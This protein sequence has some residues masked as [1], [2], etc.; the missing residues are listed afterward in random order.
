[1]GRPRKRK[2][3]HVVFDTN[4]IFTKTPEELVSADAA[5]AIREHSR[6]GDLDVKWIIPAIVRKE[7]EYQMHREFRTVLGSARR[8]AVLF[9]EPWDL[10]DDKVR[11]AI[12]AAIEKQAAQLNVVFRDCDAGRVDWVSMMHASAFRLPPFEAGQ[13]EKGFRDAIVCET[14]CQVVGDLVGGDTAVLVTSDNLI[15]QALKERI[16]GVRLLSD[17]SALRDEINLRVS[18]VDAP[19]AA[20]IE[21]KAAKV[22]YDFSDTDATG[23]LWARANLYEQIWAKFG[24]HIRAVPAGYT[25]KLEQQEI[26]GTR[27]ARKEGNQLFL[28][29]TFVVKSTRTYWQPDTPPPPAGILEPPKSGLAGLHG[30]SGSS[31]PAGLAAGLGLLGGAFGGATPAKTNSLAATLL[32][33]GGKFVSTGAPDVT[34]EIHWTATYTR[35]KSV[36]RAK[37]TDVTLHTPVDM[38]GND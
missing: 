13:T 38:E 26:H 19:T 36:S 6:H 21:G 11:A 23:T 27:L 29:T 24:D 25:W 35:Y 10:S 4:A 8:A 2:M 20:E 34:L 28:I 37:L 9:N 30:G 31:T 5:R 3:L 17:M 7:R 18:N 16:P 22:F 15:T 14:Y 1:M 33:G 12:A 32:G